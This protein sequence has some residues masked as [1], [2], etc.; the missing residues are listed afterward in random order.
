[1]PGDHPVL[2]EPHGPAFTGTAGGA[3]PPSMRSGTIYIFTKSPFCP[4]LHAPRNVTSHSQPGAVSQSDSS[5]H[6]RA[7]GSEVTALRPQ[8]SDLR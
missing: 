3:W 6:H 1:M 4:R 5:S 2:L 7:V 8:L